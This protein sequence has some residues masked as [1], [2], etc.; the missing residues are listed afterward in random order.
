MSISVLDE[1]AG[2]AADAGSRRAI[3]ACDTA[4]YVGAG[5]VHFGDESTQVIGV[6]DVVVSQIGDAIRGGDGGAVVI[7][8]ALA[9]HSNREIVPVD[10]WI[11]ERLH[12]VRR[13]ICAAVA[14]D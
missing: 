1:D 3:E 7:W 9:L 5:L 13:V 2:D 12:H 4:H 8:A 11:D 14:D 10:S 6:P